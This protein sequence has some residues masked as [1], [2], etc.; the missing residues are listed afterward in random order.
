MRKP[1]KQVEI[2]LSDLSLM[3]FFPLICLR[4]DAL[5]QNNN[6]MLSN[7]I[8]QTICSKC[9]LCKII[10][11]IVDYKILYFYFKQTI[12]ELRKIEVGSQ[13]NLFSLI[14]AENVFFSTLL[15]AY[16]NLQAKNVQ[17]ICE[18]NKRL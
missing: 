13:V 6:T 8:P 17:E 12:A 15:K 2:D 7:M 3:L 16:V 4:A 5:S 10:A 9:S 11:F 18:S 1:I 14:N